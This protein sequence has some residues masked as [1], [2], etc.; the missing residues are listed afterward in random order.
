MAHSSLSISPQSRSYN[1]TH[2]ERTKK[3]VHLD[4]VQ[5]VHIIRCSRA[6]LAISLTFVSC[7]TLSME[8]NL[9]RSCSPLFVFSV[10]FLFYYYLVIY[11]FICIHI[12]DISLC[13]CFALFLLFQLWKA[14]PFKLFFF[15]R[16]AVGFFFVSWLWWISKLGIF[17]KTESQLPRNWCCV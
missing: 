4:Y 2:T 14:L 7:K 12:F 6:R 3:S 15:F 5:S 13:F 16:L 11:S 9:S 1:N 17:L 8:L 10:Q